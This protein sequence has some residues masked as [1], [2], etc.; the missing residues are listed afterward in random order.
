MFRK[1]LLGLLFFVCTL[2]FTTMSC[3]AKQEFIFGV[4]PYQKP[5]E[6]VRMFTPLINY[7]EE[8]TGAHITFQTAK[9]Y[10]EAMEKMASGEMDIFYV[11]PAPFVVLLEKYPDRFRIAATVV[12]Q[13]KPTYK[14]VIVI[15]DISP[16]TTMAE[17][18][19][20][21]FA[22]GDPRSTLSCY[23]PAQMLLK[24]GVFDS[25]HYKFLGSHDNVAK[26]VIRGFFDGGGIKPSVA[27]KYEGKGLKI[28]AESEPVY[29]HLIGVGPDV[30]DAT[31]QKIK[32]ALL[33]VSDEKIYQSIKPSL[34]GF[35]PTEISDYNNLREIVKEVDAKLAK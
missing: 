32:K 15:R 2:H 8:V 33:K 11:G 23:M 7:L 20:K 31:F 34:T 3:L 13:G 29:E 27:K 24:A 18:K 1:I 9:N 5:Y 25:V 30:D 4:H 22:F 16:I 19:D 14:G 10:N 12:N 17:F 21:K 35:T 28:I 26:A 6:L